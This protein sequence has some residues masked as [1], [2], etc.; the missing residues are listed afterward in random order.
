MEAQVPQAA[1]IAELRVCTDA[2]SIGFFTTDIEMKIDPSNC[3]RVGT[4]LLSDGKR[5]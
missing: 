2:P 1:L 3:E 4:G 5:K